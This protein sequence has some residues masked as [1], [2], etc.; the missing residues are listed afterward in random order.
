MKALE[1]LQ[2]E[3]ANQSGTHAYLFVGTNSAAIE[4]MIGAVIRAKNIQLFDINTIEPEEADGKTGDITVKTVRVFLHDAYLSPSGENRLAIIRRAEHLNLASANA[5]LKI[6]E[7]P[8]PHL[9]LILTSATDSILPTIKS[10][11]RVLKAIGEAQANNPGEFKEVMALSFTAAS[12]RFETFAKEGG[13]D[14]FLED[15]IR[16]FRN[17][18]IRTKDPQKSEAIKNIT[19]VK[20]AVRANVNSRLA[21][22]NLFILVKDVI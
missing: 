5:L 8:P 1:V 11:C 18:L 20:R 3:A 10:R 13:T 9:T 22:E 6:L 2:Q 7:E 16:Y 15:G 12:K 4:E 17:E 19:A 21:L 14:E